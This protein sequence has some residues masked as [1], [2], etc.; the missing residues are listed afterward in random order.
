MD[1]TAQVVSKAEVGK[2]H[3]LIRLGLATRTGPGEIRLLDGM[4]SSWSGSNWRFTP[5]GAVS[6]FVFAFGQGA[7]FAVIGRWVWT[8]V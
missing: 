4:N 1:D 5:P 6:L 2:D 3:W 7:V 8:H